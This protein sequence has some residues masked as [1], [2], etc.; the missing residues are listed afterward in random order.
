MID[1]IFFKF[2]NLI[3]SIQSTEIKFWRLFSE[4]LAKVD[5]NAWKID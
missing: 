3:A 2:E 1:F 5:W 4:N